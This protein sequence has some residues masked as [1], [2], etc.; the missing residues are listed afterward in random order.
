V[1][2]YKQWAKKYIDYVHYTIPIQGASP[3]G[4]RFP[5]DYAGQYGVYDA[6]RHIYSQ[7]KELRPLL[8]ED[9]LFVN[10]KYF[11]NDLEKAIEGVRENFRQKHNIKQNGAVVFF[12]PGNEVSE[13]EFCLDTVRR[14][15]KEFV[16]KYSSPTSLS[17]KAPPIDHYTTIISLQKGSRVEEY[18]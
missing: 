14:G 3:D 9:S 1:K 11:A 6:V 12:A 15:V 8:K 7:S 5:S 10:R 17:P 18:V 4:F 16:L 2:D 13:A